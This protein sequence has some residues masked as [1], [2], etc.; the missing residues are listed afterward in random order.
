MSTDRPEHTDTS[1]LSAAL[2][3]IGA[4]LADLGARL[5]RLDRRLE[6]RLAEL[7]AKQ[8]EDLMLVKALACQLRGRV[9][10]V[11]RRTGRA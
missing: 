1:S 3:R 11:E 4:E 10:R 6:Q 7:R 5:D 9:E 2:Q 8:D